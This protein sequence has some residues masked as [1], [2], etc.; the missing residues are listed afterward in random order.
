MQEEMLTLKASLYLQ[1]ARD[2]ERMFTVTGDG[3]LRVQKRLDAIALSCEVFVLVQQVGKELLAV[4]RRN[5]S[6]LHRFSGEVDQEMHNS[7][8]NEISKRFVRTTS[9]VLLA[10]GPVSFV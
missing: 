4:Q 1:S 7:L 2:D 5:Q 8:Y 6:V 3:N 9:D 10:L